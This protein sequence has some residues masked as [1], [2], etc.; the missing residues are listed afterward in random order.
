MTFIKWS[1]PYRPT[2]ILW[3]V[4]QIQEQLPITCNLPGFSKM[5]SQKVFKG[6]KHPSHQRNFTAQI[7]N[8]L[9][10]RE[11]KCRSG[12]GPLGN[13]HF[14]MLCLT[15]GKQVEEQKCCTKIIF[16]RTEWTRTN[17]NKVINLWS[18]WLQNKTSS[19]SHH[20]WGNSIWGKKYLLHEEKINSETTLKCDYKIE[21]YEKCQLTV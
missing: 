1:H 14:G 6:T 2:R 4:Q 8:W 5:P 20:I 13:F 19:K 11:V 21:L 9:G 7:N 3:G 15:F 16:F 18:E 10:G 17:E 12:E